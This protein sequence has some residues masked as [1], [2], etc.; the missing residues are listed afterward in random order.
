MVLVQ[1]V[2]GV[3]LV[4]VVVVVVISPVQVHKR[5]PDPPG[6]AS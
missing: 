4:V 3:E 1:V 5:L 2:V 6:G